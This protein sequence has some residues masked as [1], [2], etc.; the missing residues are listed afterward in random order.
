MRSPTS[1]TKAT[2]SPIGIMSTVSTPRA[3]YCA[4]KAR[5]PSTSSSGLVRARIVLSI[6][7]GSRASAS[8]CRSSTSSLRAISS[9]EMAKRLQASA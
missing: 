8:Q 9:G 7:A 3:A 5:K 2:G 6:E 4:I 1:V